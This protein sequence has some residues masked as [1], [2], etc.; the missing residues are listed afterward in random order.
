MKNYTREIRAQHGDKVYREVIAFDDLDKDNN[1]IVV[2]L[3]RGYRKSGEYIAV[4]VQ[5]LDSHGIYSG[6]MDL[7]PQAEWKDETI[8]GVKCAVYVLNPCWVLEPTA[9]N[10]KKIL[11][12]IARRAFE[13][14]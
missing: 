1:K 7:N 13:S 5:R 14:K 8:N 6:A 2:E 9:E 11:G 12:E 4:D 10:E 3:S